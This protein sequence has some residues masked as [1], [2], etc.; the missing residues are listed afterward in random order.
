MSRLI[1]LMTIKISKVLMQKWVFD[2][3]RQNLKVKP[4]TKNISQFRLW[5]CTIN[6]SR[7]NLFRL[8]RCP[9]NRYNSRAIF[10]TTAVKPLVFRR[11]WSESYYAIELIL[12]KLY[13]GYN[14][15]WRTCKPYSI[16]MV[17]FKECESKIHQFFWKW[18]VFVLYTY[19]SN[20]Q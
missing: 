17:T 1:P 8:T 2:E 10:L 12:Y 3:H 9:W 19:L 16:H 13:L 6:T 11:E 4:E 20:W 15:S 18:R 7:M 5:L 14:M